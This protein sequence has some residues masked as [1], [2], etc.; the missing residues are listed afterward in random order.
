MKTKLLLIAAMFFLFEDARAATIWNQKENFPGVAR[1]RTSCFTLGNVGYMGLGHYNSGAA[2]NVILGDF[3]AYDP[4][5]DSWTQVADFGGGLRYH[6][7]DFVYENKAY[8]GTGRGITGLTTDIWEFDPIA[9]T[10]TYVTDLP[11]WPRRGSVGFTMGE[12]GFIGCGQLQGAPS[13]TGNDFYAYHI[14]TGI[15]TMTIPDLPGP[16]RTSTC[17]FV[18]DDKA[19]VGTGS[20]SAGP[21]LDFYEYKPATNTWTQRADVGTIPRVEAYGFALNGKGHIL[22]G[23]SWSSGTNYGDM[24]EYDPATDTWTQLADFPG[25]ARRYPDGFELNGKAYMGAGTNGTNFKDLWEYN[26][27]NALSVLELGNITIKVYPNPAVDFITFDLGNS[28]IEFTQ[29]TRVEIYNS[30]GELVAEKSFT[31]NQLEI[32]LSNFTGGTYIYSIKDS[33]EIL[34]NGKIQIL[35]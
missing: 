3:W 13:F 22:C 4:S 11:S 2:G 21:G 32:E 17:S 25:L 10:W 12:Y 19:Y 20:T 18:I 30:L 35:K 9:N 33:D 29:R 23:A 8:V 34:A 27:A 15:W 1:H 31:D 6:A 14:P 26:P 28:G 7:A 24:Y 5:S 16:E